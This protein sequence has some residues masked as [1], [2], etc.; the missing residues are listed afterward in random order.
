M[1]CSNPNQALDNYKTKLNIKIYKPI[2]GAMHQSFASRF[3][4]SRLKTNQLTCRGK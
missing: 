2:S 3:E 4:N 1:R